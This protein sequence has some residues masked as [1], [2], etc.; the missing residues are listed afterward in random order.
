MY[1]FYAPLPTAL[2]GFFRLLRP[3]A[4]CF[5]PI[6][7]R[8]FEGVQEFGRAKLLL[9]CE[10]MRRNRLGASLALPLSA[11]I[12]PIEFAGAVRQVRFHLC[13][14]LPAIFSAS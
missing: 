7:L 9:S 5:T 11:M 4:I 13:R 8:Q 1:V 12:R 2:D 6:D 10:F 3:P 14:R